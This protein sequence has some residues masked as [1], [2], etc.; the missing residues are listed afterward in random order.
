MLADLVAELSACAIDLDILCL[1]WLELIAPALLL[2]A[3]A[4]AG[5]FAARRNFGQYTG[6]VRLGALWAGIITA[7]GAVATGWFVFFDPATVH[8]A[9]SEPSAQALWILA[10]SLFGC[11]FSM[12]MGIAAYAAGGS[13]SR[14]PS[15]RER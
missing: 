3:L 12:L 15:E 11:G 5:L 1:S 6:R 9:S 7:L 10:A 13:I 14:G 4:A 2:V 8:G